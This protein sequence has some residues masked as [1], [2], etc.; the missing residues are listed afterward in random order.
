MR[1][2]AE[3][4]L[5]TAR[6]CSRRGNARQSRDGTC[7]ICRMPPNLPKIS[8]ISSAEM[9]KGRLR[10]KSTLQA[11]CD[12][13]LPDEDTVFRDATSPEGC[14]QERTD[15]ALSARAA[16]LRFSRRAGRLGGRAGQGAAG[17]CAAYLFTS[18]GSRCALFRS[19]AMPAI[20]DDDMVTCD[21]APRYAA[22]PLKQHLRSRTLAGGRLCL[23]A[24]RGSARCCG[25]G[26]PRGGAAASSHVMT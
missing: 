17:G 4:L 5:A 6:C 10:T 3:M 24:R 23:P 26:L 11:A 2:R 12:S 25:S 13:V 8:Y 14:A 18:G 22:P 9:L 7:R 1:A 15:A 19:A 20:A 16:L 21:A